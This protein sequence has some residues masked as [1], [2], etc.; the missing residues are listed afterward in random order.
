MDVSEILHH[1]VEILTDPAHSAVEFTFVLFDVLVI[2]FVRRRLVKHFHKD[3]TSQHTTLDRE[4][5]VAFHGDLPSDHPEPL[6]AQEITVLRSMAAYQTEQ[7]NAGT[8]Q[9][10][11]DLFFEPS[12]DRSTPC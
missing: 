10:L 3:L 1:Y 8:E 6:S 12:H 11:R 5:G 7:D 2:D 4:H 9:D